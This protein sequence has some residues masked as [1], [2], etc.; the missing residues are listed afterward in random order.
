METVSALK[1][2][3][4]TV[5][6]PSSMRSS[7]GETVKIHGRDL[8]LWYGTMH[9]LREIRME[10]RAHEITALIGPSGCGKSSFLRCL[11]RMNELI[12]GARLRGEVLLDAANIYARSV[13]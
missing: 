7:P 12:P 8:N 3:G 4:A 9:A 11:N 10:I 5:A 13:D 1:Q 2:D 6:L